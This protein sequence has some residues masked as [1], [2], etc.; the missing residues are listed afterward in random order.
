[1]RRASM[2]SSS[3]EMQPMAKPYMNFGEFLLATKWE[4]EEKG[5]EIE[6]A[7]SAV[8]SAIIDGVRPP[9][10]S[11]SF[12]VWADGYKRGGATRRY[13]MGWHSPYCGITTGKTPF[14]PNATSRRP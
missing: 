10:N 1:M 8:K 7:V 14:A 9:M 11:L 13:P 6:A 12:G 3:K 5:E 2:G 4:D